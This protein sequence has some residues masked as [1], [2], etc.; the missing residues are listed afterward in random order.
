MLIGF[1]MNHY[2]Y[3]DGGGYFY[4]FQLDL[5]YRLCLLIKR[6]GYQLIYKVH[7]DRASEV[8]SLFDEVADTVERRPFE[9][10]W[11]NCSHYV[12]SH[13]GSTVFGHAVFTEKPI[14][15]L[16]IETNNWNPAGYQ[17]LRERC[18]TVSTNFDSDNRL[19][20]DELEFEGKLANPLVLNDDYINSYS[21]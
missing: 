7:P 6:L 15:L 14:L 20:F 17:L 8:G 19:I 18:H 3:L 5:Q 12:F 21:E 4:Y 16:D 2:R 11:N 9:L 13:P 1:G 10:T